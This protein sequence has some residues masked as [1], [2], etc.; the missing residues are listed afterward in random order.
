M[1]G[2]GD[3]YGW[4]ERREGGG[5]EGSTLPHP[6]DHYCQYLPSGTVRI[7]VKHRKRKGIREGIEEGR[8]VRRQE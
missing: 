7:G 4:R 5:R 6:N 2:R 3:S 8:E 1:E